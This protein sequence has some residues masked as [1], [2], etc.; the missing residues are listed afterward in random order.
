MKIFHSKES[1]VGV[2]IGSSGIKIVELKK[3]GGK[4]RLMS[5]GF[6][7]NPLNLDK[8]SN[9]ET[10]GVINEIYGKAGIFSRQAVSALSTFSVFSSVIS[11][12]GLNKNDDKDIDSAVQWEA[13]KVIPLP[14]EEIVLDWKK[15]DES[16][17]KNKALAVKDD[18][19]VL[20][21]GA[22]KSL[23]K[24]YIEI[25]KLAKINLLSL[26]TETFALIR[27][28]LGNDKSTV[29]VVEIGA[30]TSN[31]IIVKE[32][33]PMLSRSIDIGGTTITEAI[34][35][36]LNIG[37]ERAEQFKYDMGISAVDSPE[38][39]IPKTIA[40]T[41][42]PVV[43]EIKYAIDIFQNKGGAKVEKIILTGGS[44]LLLNLPS[45]LSKMLNLN[46]IVGDPW[47]RVSYPVDLKPALDDL[48]P[49]L[50]T[51]IGLAMR[52]IE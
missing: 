33:I 43:N 50:S 5:Y 8:T 44:A 49:R 25:F 27:A 48:G 4:A 47:Y 13:K 42:S 15:I 23:V 40:E 41:I 12:V 7:E 9:Q 10:A 21:T 17:D 18:V 14:L 11:L 32:S 29:M 31:V 30:S 24:K 2:D 35:N 1:Y 6:S 22:P 46:V 3:E 37:K 36:N 39:A 52:E 28:L 20:L 34:S 16:Q 19:K 38:G 51:A 45:Y 26:E